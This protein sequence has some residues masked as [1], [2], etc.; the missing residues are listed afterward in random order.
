MKH[1]VETTWKENLAF[2]SQVNGHNIDLDASNENGGK[3]SG[4]RPKELMLA[5]LAGCTGMDVVSI[6][7]K[8]QVE[9]THF[10]IKIEAELTEEHP[11]HYKKM[12]LIYIFSGANIEVEKLQKAISLSQERYCGVFFMYKQIME[13][14]SEIQVLP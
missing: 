9:L 4:A 13:I 5:A 2:T 7:K 11:K 8:M 6:L 3:D 1:I 12:N 14:T 10:D